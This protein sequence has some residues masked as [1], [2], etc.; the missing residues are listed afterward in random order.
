LAGTAA[1]GTLVTIKGGL[2]SQIDLDFCNEVRDDTCINCP[3][4][5]VIPL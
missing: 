3:S 5:S 4:R 1:G 2:L